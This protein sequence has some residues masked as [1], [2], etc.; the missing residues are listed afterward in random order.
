MDKGEFGQ[1]EECQKWGDD[2][3]WA[4]VKNV[5]ECWVRIETGR[6]LLM[7]FWWKEF[8]KWVKDVEEVSEV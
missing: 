1:R 2:L 4:D 5:P 3:T 8:E 6:N 7:W